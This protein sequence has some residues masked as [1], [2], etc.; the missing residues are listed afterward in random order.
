MNVC[1]HVY[2]CAI[3]VPRAQEGDWR[4]PNPLELKLWMVMSNHMVLGNE[5]R[6]TAG[7]ASAL[8]HSDSSPALNFVLS[9]RRACIQAATDA[10]GKVRKGG[11]VQICLFHEPGFLDPAQCT[12]G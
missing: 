2:M 3:F 8:D 11:M 1:L 4:T 5:P 6:S 7:A 10:L 9:M 12:C